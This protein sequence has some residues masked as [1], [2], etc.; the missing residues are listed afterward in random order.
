MI[1]FKTSSR[2]ISEIGSFLLLRHEPCGSLVPQR[3]KTQG[4]LLSTSFLQIL[5]NPS[6]FTLTNMLRIREDW[7]LVWKFAFIQ[8]R[9]SLSCIKYNKLAE[10]HFSPFFR[11]PTFFW[12]ISS[13]SFSSIWFRNW[14][15]RTSCKQRFLRFG[16]KEKRLFRTIVPR[17]R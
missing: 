1:P 10:S 16:E 17:I 2:L 6:N 4:K 11:G 15:F 5:V 8:F 9:L 3:Q 12:T 14:T 7:H 13:L